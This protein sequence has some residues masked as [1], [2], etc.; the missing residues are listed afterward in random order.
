MADL[1]KPLKPEIPKVAILVPFISMDAY[2][3]ECIKHCLD[4]KYPDF[5]LVLLPD[6]P[7]KENFSDKRIKVIPTGKVHQA[8]KRN[9]ALFSGLKFDIAASIDSDA[10]PGREWLAR[11]V[12]IIQADDRVAAVG[13]PNL[14]PYNAGIMER[15]AV[16]IV[17]SRL[18]VGGAYF[19][20][21]YKK[22]SEVVKEL[23]SSN[24]IF[25][26]DLAAS[27]GGYDYKTYKTGEDTTFCFEI[28]KKG[29]L[30]IYSEDVVVYHHRRPL[31]KSHLERVY[32]QAADKYLILSRKV[33]A[34]FSER[35]I[36]FIPSL[37]LA[38]L[39]FGSLLSLFSTLFFELFLMSLGLYFIV[40]YLEACTKNEILGIPLFMLG[41]FLTHITYGA[42]FI[43]GMILKIR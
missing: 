27:I 42:G 20:R 6:N 26:R 18:G 21:K 11:A 15:V 40:L 2:V 13:G 31:F 10:Y 17:H 23:P 29:F 41:T 39:F 9:I 28:R 14:K 36:Y 4:L 16:D 43:K 37:F 3:R 22:N 8:V 1:K 38:Y 35:M 30:I 12:S 19:I 7:L 25:R 24:L 32:E 5:I 34:G 33:K